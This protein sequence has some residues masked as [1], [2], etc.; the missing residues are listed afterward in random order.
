MNIGYVNK[1]CNNLL[2]MIFHC[3]QKYIMTINL[4][5]NKAVLCKWVQFMYDIR[6]TNFFGQMIYQS[7]NQNSVC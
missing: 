4:N 2:Y 1:T 6:Q 5:Y 7:K 3:N